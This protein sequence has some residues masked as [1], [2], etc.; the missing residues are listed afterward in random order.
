MIEKKN[1]G[2]K[3]VAYVEANEAAASVKIYANKI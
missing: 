1:N 2:A 3:G